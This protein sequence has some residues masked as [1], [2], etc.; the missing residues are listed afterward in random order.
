MRRVSIGTQVHILALT[1]F[2]FRLTI[3]ECEVSLRICTR[4]CTVQATVL[5]F[6]YSNSIVR[7][8]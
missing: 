6:G 7:H 1:G 3:K 4:T 5:H 2:S 8:A